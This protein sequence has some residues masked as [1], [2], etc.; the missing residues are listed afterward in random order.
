MFTQLSIKLLKKNSKKLQR[1]GFSSYL[2]PETFRYPVKEN[3]VLGKE[4]TTNT[5][6]YWFHFA[7][8]ETA[9]RFR[10]S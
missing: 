2:S 5:N 8:E 1:K 4:N 3:V 6:D 7:A 10:V 9:R